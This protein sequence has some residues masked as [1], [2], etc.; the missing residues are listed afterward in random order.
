LENLLTLSKVMLCP[1]CRTPGEKN[2][3]CTH[4]RCTMVINSVKCDVKWCYV[5]GLKES[6][7]DRAN[8]EQSIFYHNVDHVRFFF[9]VYLQS[10]NITYHDDG[11]VYVVLSNK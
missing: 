1:G 10:V 4:M 5:C 11:S 3:A 7:C 6:E 8:G 9:K 2:D